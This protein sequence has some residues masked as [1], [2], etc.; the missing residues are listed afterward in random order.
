MASEGG[1][2][3]GHGVFVTSLSNGEVNVSSPRFDLGWNA[4]SPSMPGTAVVW[5]GEVYEVAARVDSGHGQRWV[6]RPWPESVTMRRVVQLDCALV[7]SRFE[8]ELSGRRRRRLRWWTIP[9]LPLL[10]LAPGSVQQRLAEDWG[11]A[12][13]VATWS[14]ALVEMLLGGFAVVQGLTVVFG[15]EWFMPTWLR[16]SIVIGPLLF[17]EALVRMVLAVANDEPVGSLL[18]WPLQLFTDESVAP[19]QSPNPIVRV[20]QGQGDAI[21]VVSLDYRRDWHAGGVLPYRGRWYRLDGAA[22]QGREWVYRFLPCNPP[23]AGELSLGLRPRTTD[24]APKP[25]HS[26]PSLV[27]TTLI[28]AAVTL[29]PRRD[30]EAW[31]AYLDVRPIW[32]TIVGAGAELIGGVFNLVRDLEGGLPVFVLLN[33]FLVAEGL[34]RLGA[35]ILGRPMA[36]L[37]GFVVRPLYRR[38]LPS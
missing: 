20:T 5:E 24:H 4:A 11:V 23:E 22:R 32:F 30:Q 9:I 33:G 10:G 34:V 29:G 16:W 27:A 14:S 2:D 21:E 12:S 3:L 35:A 13:G 8:H 18:G 38:L 6:L 25:H 36:S 37:L 28:T 1:C 26:A 7:A 19:S 31:G 15:G 17:F